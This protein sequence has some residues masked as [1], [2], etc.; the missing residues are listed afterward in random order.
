MPRLIFAD[1][2]TDLF[3]QMEWTDA[4]GAHARRVT[5]GMPADVLNA[6]RAL[7]RAKRDVKRWQIDRYGTTH[8]TTTLRDGEHSP[9]EEALAAALQPHAKKLADWLVEYTAEW[10]TKNNLYEE[11]RQLEH[12]LDLVR[13]RRLG[14]T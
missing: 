8:V 9:R 5:E 12:E 14:N 6:C 7:T 13:Q 2:G 10:V 3:V 11:E 4:Y 1:L